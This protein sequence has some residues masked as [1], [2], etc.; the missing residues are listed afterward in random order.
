MLS[1]SLNKT[2]PSLFQSSV[3][4]AVPIVRRTLIRRT[5][6]V[7]RSTPGRNGTVQS[8]VDSVVSS[9]TGQ[10]GATWGNIAQW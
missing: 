4:T 9:D 6:V 10:H 2:F 1:A 7:E 3:L 5:S 8:G